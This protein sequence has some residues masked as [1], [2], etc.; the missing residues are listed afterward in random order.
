MV[1]A[2]NDFDICELSGPLYRSVVCV[3]FIITMAL[4]VFDHT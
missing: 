1:A 4:M 3:S 2:S